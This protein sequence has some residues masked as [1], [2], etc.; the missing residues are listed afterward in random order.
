MQPW[1]ASPVPNDFCAHNPFTL[2]V[3]ATP[4]FQLLA[5]TPA[6]PGTV[7]SPSYSA[8]NICCILPGFRHQQ[9]HL[10]RTDVFNQTHN[11]LP[12]SVL[13]ANPSP[14]LQLSAQ[15]P[16]L[17]ESSAV[18]AF[19]LQEAPGLLPSS[20]FPT[21]GNSCILYLHLPEDRDPILVT[22]WSQHLNLAQNVCTQ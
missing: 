22:L 4:S 15:A 9:K 5:Q 10:T 1:Y 12:K 16:S 19:V 3:L 17:P 13:L 11:A 20:F 6:Q 21:Q 2:F 18:D 8:A 14:T 7:L